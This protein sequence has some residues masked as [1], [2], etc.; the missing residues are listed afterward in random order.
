M[1]AVAA[2][3]TNVDQT[4]CLIYHGTATVIGDAFFHALVGTIATALRVRY[5]F[6]AEFTNDNTAVR[7]LA[8]WADNDYRATLSTNWRVRHAR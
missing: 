2:K 1:G 3:L 7:T 5:A 6:I 4:R 8:V